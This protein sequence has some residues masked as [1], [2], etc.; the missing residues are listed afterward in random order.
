[1][2]E[3]TDCKIIRDLFPSYIDGLTDEETDQYIEKHLKECEECKEILESMKNELEADITERNSKPV[4]YIK[5]FNNKMR[6]LKGILL[7]ILLIFILS[8]GRKMLIIVSLNNK[9]SNY[10]S[11][12]NYYMKTFNYYGDKLIVTEQY[13]KDDKYISRVKF[14]SETKNKGIYTDYYNGETVNTYSE[15]EL[16]E[17][18][19]SRK[20]VK[21]NSVDNIIQPIIPNTIKMD[22]AGQFIVTSLF[23]SITSEEC[24]GKNCY[25]VELIGGQIYYIDKETGLTI[26]IMGETSVTNSYGERYDI[27][28]DFQYKFDVVTDDD[29]IEPDIS[30]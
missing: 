19:V 28:T 18:N 15:V 3:I 2:K 6:I 27:I 8:V 25:R 26:R 24:N 20:L 4:K 7:A 30:E 9:I 12:T 16:G 22:H 23:S 10:T 14:L 1:M 29:F 5:K 11:S 13:K 21:A 17:G